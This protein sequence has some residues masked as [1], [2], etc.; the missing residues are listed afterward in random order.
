[1]WFNKLHIKA[2]CSSVHFI[3]LWE[4]LWFRESSPFLG[5]VEWERKR[6]RKEV[7]IKGQASGG[8]N[9]QC[10]RTYFLGMSSIRVSL[11]IEGRRI[12][13]GSGSLPPLGSARWIAI[14]TWACCTRILW[15]HSAFAC[16]GFAPTLSPPLQ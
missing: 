3:Y 5:I 1:M 4:L 6:K 8:F 11:L 13:F 14:S 16:D 10:L 15:L 12:W 7:E 2:V 9:L